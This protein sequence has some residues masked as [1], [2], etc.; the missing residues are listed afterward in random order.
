MRLQGCD[1]HEKPNRPCCAGLRYH[2]GMTRLAALG[3]P[4]STKGGLVWGA[5]VFGS[6]GAVVISMAAGCGTK[7]GGASPPVGNRSYVATAGF[8][9][10][11]SVPLRGSVVIEFGIDDHIVLSTGCNTGTG[12]CR[13]VHGRLMMSTLGMDEMYCRIELHQQQ[14]FVVKVVTSEPLASMNGEVLTLVSAHGEL[15]FV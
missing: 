3:C 14:E 15:R 4:W 5:G 2:P 13:I 10:G 9:D 12:Q 11:K 7:V 6:L 8:K 1:E